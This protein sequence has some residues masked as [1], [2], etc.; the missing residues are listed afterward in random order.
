MDII[1]HLT[2]TVS[3]A[4]LGDDRAPE[5]MRLLEQFYAI[6]AAKLADPEVFNRFSSENIAHNDQGFYDR[7]WTEGSHKEQIANELAAENNVDPIA[8]RGLIAMAAPLAYH[9]IKSLAGTTPVP[10][11]LNDNLASYQHHIP[12]WA[13]GLLPVGMVAAAAPTVAAVPVPPPGVRISDTVS[14]APLEKTPERDGNFMKALLPIIGL[15]ILGALAWALLRGCQNNPE[16]VGTPVITDQSTTVDHQGVEPASIRI[17]TGDTPGSL[18]ACRINVGNEDLHSTVMGAMNSTF[19]GDADKCRADVDDNFASDMPA[20]GELA[21]ILPLVNGVPNAT[22]FIKG[23]DIVVNAPDTAALQK[24]V[25]DIQAAAPSMNVMAEK[26][27]DLQSEIDSSIKAATVAVDR[28]GDSPDPRDVARAL[29]LQVVHFDVDKAIIPEVNKPILDRAVEIMKKVPDM[30]LLITGHT[31][32]T[33]DPAYNLNLSKERAQS[34]KDYMVSKGADPEK[35]I[36]Q[37]KGETEPVADN[38]TDQGRFRNRRIEFTVY[39]ET[40]MNNDVAIADIGGVNPVA[41]MPADNTVT[42]IEQQPMANAGTT[43]TPPTTMKTGANNANLNNAANNT[44]NSA[45]VNGTNSAN[46]GARDPNT[47]PAPAPKSSLPAPKTGNNPAINPNDRGN[48][49]ILPDATDPNRQPR[50]DPK[51]DPKQ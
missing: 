19:G 44:N 4:V 6:F 7:I 39:D 1:S 12:L 18:Y 32:S 42:V 29:S 24:L 26:P 17:A 43:V 35:L 21:K 8:S 38:S 14:T 40:A 10:Q 22:A 34:M 47:V 2:R 50:L 11:F 31:D 51:A 28:L 27:L 45:N 36:I 33:A 16:P 3:P 9:E 41:P 5:K 49:D 48:A 20:S 15:I 46:T 23:N 13:A 37:G 25:S 30:K